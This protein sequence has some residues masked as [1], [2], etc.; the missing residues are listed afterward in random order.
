MCLCDSQVIEDL[1]RDFKNTLEKQQSLEEWAEWLMRVVERM[2]KPSRDV[3]EFIEAARQFLLKW[4]FYRCFQNGL[5][6]L[7]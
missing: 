1:E 3:G 6:K 7:H 5:I 2:L 4:S